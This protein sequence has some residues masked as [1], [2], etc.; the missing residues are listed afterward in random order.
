MTADTLY[1]SLSM[2]CVLPF[3]VGLDVTRIAGRRIYIKV[4]ESTI[5]MALHIGSMAGFAGYS[6]FDN[7]G[8]VSAEIGAMTCE[9]RA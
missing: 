1:A 4:H 2:R 3:L 8:M 7:Q 6:W 5:R 9:A